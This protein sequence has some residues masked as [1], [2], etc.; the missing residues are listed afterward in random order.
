MKTTRSIISEKIKPT[1]LLI[2][3]VAGLFSCNSAKSQPPT[4][5][6]VEKCLSP[7][8]LVMSDN[9]DTDTLPLKSTSADVT[10]A[11]VIANVKVTQ[12]YK[13]EGKNTL[14]AI[15]V[16][17]ASTRAAVHAMKMTIGE[18][19]IEAV[20]QER[21]QAR[22]DYEKAK[23]EGK[24]ASLL[25]QM[26]PNV[27]QMNVANILPGDVIKVEMSYTELL[28]PEKG[29]YEF[30]YP[31]VV[32]PR[33]S[34]KSESEATPSDQWVANPYT[35][36]G[37]K[38]LNTFGIHVNL[39]TGMPVKDV[40]CSTHETDIA[41]T[42]ANNA[43]IYLKKGNDYEGN[44]DFILKYRLKGNQIQSGMILYEGKDENFFLAMVQP[45]QRITPN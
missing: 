4:D 24:S 41:Y 14:E 44:R 8:F 34:N 30:V 27:F 6:D 35:T 2:L 11:G 19:V 9:S 12:V 13:N 28:V 20:I 29:V 16:F 21:E 40:T 3:V 33:Y 7:Y 39:N 32:G 17:P 45:P 25:E 15:Y 23:Q 31:T 10:I 18:R 36:E 26:R 37:K 5:K 43:T 22:R 38:P 1:M 42:G